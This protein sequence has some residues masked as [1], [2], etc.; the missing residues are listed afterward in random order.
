MHFWALQLKKAFECIQRRATRLEGLS[1]PCDFELVLFEAKEVE[2]KL[3]CSAS[4]E[5][6]LE[7]EVLSSPPG[8]LWQNM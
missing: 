5:G 8:T 4:W 7:R 1:L 3:C 6:E 2:G